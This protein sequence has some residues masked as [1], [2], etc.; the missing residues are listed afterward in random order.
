MTATAKNDKFTH[1]NALKLVTAIE[2]I[3]SYYIHNNKYSTL[4]DH[5]IEGLVGHL[6]EYS[7]YLDSA[8]LTM[9][10]AH[11]SG[12]LV[13]I[14]TELQ[15][16]KEGLEIISSFEKSPAALAHLQPGDIITHIN[17]ESLQD[18]TFSKSLMLFKGLASSTIEISV[19]SPEKNT[20]R[21]IVLQRQLITPFS[22]HYELLNNNIAYIKIPIFTETSD[23]EVENAIDILNK[24]TPI[25][26]LIIDLRGN[27]G[28]LLDSAVRT[29]DL[30]LD[31]KRLHKNTTIVSTKSRCEQTQFTAM[32][33]P[34]DILHNK[35]IVVLINR[36][37]A[38]SSEI[39]ASALQD[40]HRAILVGQKTFGKGSIQSLISLDNESAIKITTGLYQTPTGKVIQDVGVNPDII[41]TPPTQTYSLKNDPFITTALTTIGEKKK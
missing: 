28:G 25:E 34:G 6:D 22:A 10:Q 17:N 33:T 14:G 2:Q 19:Y 20:S 15:P 16:H 24:K 7:E 12:Q 41:I 32:A 27:P 38:S 29:S 1:D 37:S 4:V 35:P 13:G 23:Q 26:G 11:N 31:S 9:M 18:K 39:M 40:H 30:F 21:N 3:K 36:G 5:A 8:A